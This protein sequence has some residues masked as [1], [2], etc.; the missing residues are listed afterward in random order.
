MS[1]SSHA[2]YTKCQIPSCENEAVW[3]FQYNPVPH[4][5]VIILFCE[6]HK[7]LY[8]N[9]WPVKISKTLDSEHNDYHSKLLSDPVHAR[10]LNVPTAAGFACHIAQFT[11]KIPRKVKPR[12]ITP[13]FA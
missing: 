2:S 8:E 3:A 6:L 4:G 9:D 1:T 5:T 7:K 11:I 13:S 10:S 12:L